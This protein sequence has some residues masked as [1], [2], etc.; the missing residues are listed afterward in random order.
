MEEV[1]LYEKEM[2]KYMEREH[3]EIIAQID[4]KQ[5]LDEALSES[6]KQALDAFAKEFANI[7]EG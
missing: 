1:Q 3:H 4:E 6:I 5:A 7:L 2:L